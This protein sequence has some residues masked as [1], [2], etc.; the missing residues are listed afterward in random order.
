MYAA[1]PS[2]FGCN[3]GQPCVCLPTDIDV[4]IQIR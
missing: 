4:F 1:Q 3:M 2:Q